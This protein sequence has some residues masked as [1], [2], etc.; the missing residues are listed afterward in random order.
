MYTDHIPAYMTALLN[1][2]M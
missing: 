1:V 2:D